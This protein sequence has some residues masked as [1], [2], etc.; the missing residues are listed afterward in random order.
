MIRLTT[1]PRFLFSVAL[2]GILLLGAGCQRQETVQRTDRLRFMA[3]PWMFGKYPIR[4]AKERFEKRH[5]GVT[6]ELLKVGGG[7]LARA[8]RLPDER[9]Q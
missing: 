1:L 5:P 4:E 3:H 7:G 6:V 9:P 8:A 2:L